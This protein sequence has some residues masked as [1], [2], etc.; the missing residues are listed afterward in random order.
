MFITVGRFCPVN[1]SG[2]FALCHSLTTSKISLIG[3]PLFGSE[4][5]SKPAIFIEYIL[6]FL[7]QP[8]VLPAAIPA[9]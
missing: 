5:P 7:A 2:V 4:D 1:T 6:E 9:Q 8:Y 3:I